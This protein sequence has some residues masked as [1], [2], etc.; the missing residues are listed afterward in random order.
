MAT[1]TDKFITSTDVLNL[2][3]KHGVENII[4]IIPLRPIHNVLIINYTSSDDEPV[5]IPCKIIETRYKVE[6]DYKIEFQSM[7]QGYGKESFYMS[8][9]TQLLRQ[10]YIQIFAKII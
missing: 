5:K 8:D 7:I 1:N 10:N 4:A 9:F 3:K 6:S 2:I